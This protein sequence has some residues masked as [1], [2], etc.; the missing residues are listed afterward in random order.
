MFIIS[1]Q[2][3]IYSMSEWI[4][5]GKY[6]IFRVFQDLAQL[7]EIDKMDFNYCVI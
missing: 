3:W 5:D 2:R 4:E 1:S 7:E 6:V